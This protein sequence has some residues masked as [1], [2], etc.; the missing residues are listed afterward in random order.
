MNTSNNRNDHLGNS[1]KKKKTD[2][3]IIWFNPPF[4]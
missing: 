2:R 1:N 4:F 3:K